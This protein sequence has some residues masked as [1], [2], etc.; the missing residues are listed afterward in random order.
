MASLT[1][2]MLLLSGPLVAAPLARAESTL[3]VADGLKVTIEYTLTLPDK[4]VADSNVGQAPFSYIQGAK[5]IVPGLEKGLAGL[6][7]GQQKRVEVPAE[8]GYG[9]YD[10]K[11][12]IKV[13]RNKIPPDVK[14]GSMLQDQTGRPVTVLELS[15]DSATLDLNH[16][17]AGKA[18][19]FDV[20]ILNVEKAQQP[21]P[22]SKKP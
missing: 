4:T 20:K 1:V 12:K 10:E 18:L 14:V 6:K 3:A 11:R 2:L 19:T 21:S 17:L 15:T 7:A 16:P 22:G 13:P 8:Q 9:A 5:Q